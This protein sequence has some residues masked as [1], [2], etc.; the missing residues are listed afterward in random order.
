MSG[1]PM[2]VSLSTVWGT[3]RNPHHQQFHLQELAQVIPERQE[4]SRHG[5]RDQLVELILFYLY[6]GSED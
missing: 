5:S 6:L 3:H 2:Q 4:K 1:C